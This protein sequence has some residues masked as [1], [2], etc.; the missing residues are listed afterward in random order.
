[1]TLINT[2]AGKKKKIKNYI[3]FFEQQFLSLLQTEPLAQQAHN[4]PFLTVGKLGGER[5]KHRN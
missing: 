5:K 3:L 2:L 4:F 1:L